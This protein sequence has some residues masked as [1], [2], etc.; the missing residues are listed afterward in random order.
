MAHV[1]SIGEPENKS[2]AKAIRRLAES[3]PKDYYL[4]HNFELTTGSGL[5]YEY[6]LAVL[7]DYALWHVE[8]KGYRG[9][10]KG[11]R[12][13]W[14]FENG[15]I[16]PSPIPLA[17]KKSKILASLLRKKDRRL[18]DVWV[19]TAVLLTDDRA[20]VRLHDEQAGRV[21]TLDQA[22]AHF[23][24]RSKLPVQTDDIS[25]LQD[26]V[27]EV[28]LGQSPKRP[29]TQIGLYDVVE[30]ISQRTERTV[31]LANH[32]YIKTDART[33]LK[34][35]HF[36]VYAKEDERQSQIEAIFHDSDAMRMLGAHPNVIQTGDMFAWG[37]HQ[38]VL[39]TEYIEQGRP[40]RTALDMEQIEKKRDFGVKVRGLMGAARGLRHAH[41]NNI[42]HRDVRP[43][44]VV[45]AP[46]PD[47]THP[48]VKLV[49]FDLALIKGPFG[50]KRPRHFFERLHPA[51]TAPEMYDDP[52]GVDVR[53]DI[54]SLGIAFYELLT[55]ERPYDDVRELDGETPLDRERLL[56]ELSAPGSMDE[57]DAPEEAVEIIVKMCR[58]DREQR[59]ADMT[60]VLDDLSILAE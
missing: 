51:Y 10:I 15:G 37:T 54:Y 16:T 19:D 36:D 33:V 40:L 34:V 2:E 14:E 57:M 6:D 35:Y 24:D 49:N 5:P 8:V 47:P 30:R 45:V 28:L 20:K 26:P 9:M 42:I 31:F 13:Q 21:I 56:H 60:E 39:P 55:S 46:G 12:H 41:K 53:A 23:T 3:L 27:A 38:F 43:M 52:E 48:I 7:G 44:N 1:H 32:R 59:Y 22:V 17:N 29:I 18:N 58:Q 4:F 11:T 50:D 25:R